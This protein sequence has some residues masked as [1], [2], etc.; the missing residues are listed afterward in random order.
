[1]GDHGEKETQRQTLAL[2]QQQA[3]QGQKFDELAGMYLP[4]AKGQEAR[5][6]ELYNLTL[7]GLQTAVKHYT[8]LASGDT[9]AIFKE[10]AP[11]AEMRRQGERSVE[12]QITEN[13]PRG[14]EQRL[15]REMNTSAAAGDIGRLATQSYTS[16]FPALAQLAQGGIGLSMGE[17]SQTL[18]AMS[19][20][21]GAYG[22][23]AGAYG[24]AAKITGDVAQQQAQATAAQKAM[25]SSLAGAGAGVASAGLT[26]YCWIAELLY[27]VS[28]M[29]TF[30]I[31]AW[32]S[33]VQIRTWYDRIGTALYRRFGRQIAAVLRRVPALQVF[34]RPIFNHWLG[35]ASRA[36]EVR[37]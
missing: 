1:M 4:I 24:G 29:R 30:L 6:T 36:L 10:I 31:R 26:K 14:G 18:A 23:A 32:V 13:M 28:D 11:A 21:G 3:A 20:A 35:E 19:G 25:F 27:G 33:H 16:A 2:A 22:G 12:Q 7:P 15:A 8:G 5:S 37:V 34:F 17:L 9:N